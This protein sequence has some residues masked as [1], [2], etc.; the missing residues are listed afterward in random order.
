MFDSLDGFYCGSGNHGTSMELEVL[1]QATSTV[2]ILGC[3][4]TAQELKVF[5]QN[6]KHTKKPSAPIF[7]PFWN[8][9][10]DPPKQLA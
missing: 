10:R 6:R 5:R 8:L 3:G 4:D 9:Q 1:R 7:L 2:R